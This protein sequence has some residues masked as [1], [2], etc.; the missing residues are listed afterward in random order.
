MPP[1]GTTHQCQPPNGCFGREVNDSPGR[2]SAVAPGRYQPAVSAPVA[3]LPSLPM[4]FL[5]A[6]EAVL[7][8]ARR[9]LTTP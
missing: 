8:S 2:T 7:K 6:A 9:P 4:T 1:V 5:A 3:P